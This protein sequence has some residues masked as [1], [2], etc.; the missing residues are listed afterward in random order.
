MVTVK[1]PSI[2]ENNKIFRACKKE[3]LEVDKI[4]WIGSLSDWMDQLTGSAKWEI[5][6][7]IK[8]WINQTDS[9]RW[10]DSFYQSQ[11]FLLMSLEW[12][13]I[14]KDDSTYVFIKSLWYY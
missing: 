8:T 3:V 11:S 6:L 5:S 10:T 4:P 9:P 2:A 14:S 12:T 1:K 7:K 13:G